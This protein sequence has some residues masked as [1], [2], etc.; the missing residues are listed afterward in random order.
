MLDRRQGPR[1]T[2]DLLF[3]KFVEG[4][5]HLCR[6]MDL[7]VSGLR[8]LSLGEPEREA[9]SFAL[10]LGLPGAEECLWLWARRVW[11]HGPEHALEFLALRARDRERLAHYLHHAHWAEVW[12]QGSNDVPSL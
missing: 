7:S 9:S 8:A 4:Y 2:T 5:P 1:A 10:E 6:C 12:I 11:R 3:N